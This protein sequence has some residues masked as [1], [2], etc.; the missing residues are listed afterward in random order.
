M[1]GI[2]SGGRSFFGLSSF[3]YLPDDRPHPQLSVPDPPWVVS[4]AS[5]ILTAK[6]INNPPDDDDNYDDRKKGTTVENA[7]CAIPGAVSSRVVHAASY[8]AVSVD[9]APY[10][11]EGGNEDGAMIGRVEE[12]AVEAV[13]CV[14][15]EAEVLR[16]GDIEDY[17]KRADNPPPPPATAVSLTSGAAASRDGISLF[18]EEMGSAAAASGGSATFEVSGMS[19]AVCSGRVE[20]ALTSVPGVTSASVSLPTGRARA[21]FEPEAAGARGASD[22]SIGAMREEAEMDR[23]RTL[24][25]ECA[26]TVTAGGYE[27]AVF[28][29]SDPSGREEGGG[30]TLAENAARMEDARRAEQSDWR[31]HLYAALIF[32]VPLVLIHLLITAQREYDVSSPPG[33]DEWLTVYLATAVQFVV[34]RRF[35]RSA[36]K[37]FRMDRVLGMDFLVVMGTTAAYIYSII[38]F[39]IN[40]ITSLLGGDSDIISGGYQHPLRPTFETGAMLLTFVTLGKYM[41]AYAK[42]KTASALQSLMEL[43]PAIATRVQIPPE[44]VRAGN[45]GGGVAGAGVKAW[46]EVE[47]LDPKLDLT[48]L[49]KEEVDIADVNVGD[50][51]LVPPGSRVPTDGVLAARDGGAVRGEESVYVDESAFSGEPFP[52]AKSTGD[53]LW[54]SSVNQLSVLIIRVTATGADTV[55]SRIVRLIEDAQSNRAPIQAHADFIAS[56]FAP[57]V[58]VCSAFTFVC[59]I[60]FNGAVGGQERMFVALMSAISVVVVACPCALGLA[61][62]TAVMVGTGVGATNG[63]LIKGGAVLEA[64]NSVGTVVFDKTGTLTTGRAVLSK[65]VQFLTGDKAD[66]ANDPLLQGLPPGIN[67]TDVPLWLAACAEV[68]SE[69]PLANAVVNAARG[70]WGGDVSRSSEGVRVTGFCVAPGRGVEC[71]VHRDGFGT[72]CVRVG[73]QEWTNDALGVPS[74]GGDGSSAERATEEGD[75]WVLLEMFRLCGIWRHFGLSRPFLA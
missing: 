3:P 41:E 6:Q 50:Y 62:P 9:S 74:D 32:T 72:W 47:T 59:W 56:I 24:A 69:H 10:L 16:G 14:G 34:G 54:G 23:I 43:Q 63:L 19:C 65:N 61:T 75:R 18:D 57:F 40:L 15:F 4:S 28:R 38:V 17:V 68:N 5:P 8:A 35:Y 2:G 30:I 25:D 20:R 37:S 44:F 66:G 60:G 45:N 42:G 33:W 70:L 49:V 39:V 11:I 36:W 46:K 21:N 53:V 48:S 27:C 31:N 1:R 67:A 13:E 51:L 22:H 55:L 73:S 52:V 71:L 7:L 29:L 64:A 58:L 26:S 12:E